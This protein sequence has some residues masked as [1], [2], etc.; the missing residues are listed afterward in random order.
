MTDVPWTSPERP[1]IWSPGR[2]ATGSRRRT[3]T[4][5]FRTFEY[6]FFSKKQLQM[7]K[8]RAIASK[9]HFFH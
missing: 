5:P 7:C 1:I 4:S 9:K 6:L 3:M 8:T 2:P